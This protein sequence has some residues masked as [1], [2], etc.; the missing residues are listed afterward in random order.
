MQAASSGSDIGAQQSF[1]KCV[2][3]CPVYS[4]TTSMPAS[5]TSRI[6]R[7]RCSPFSSLVGALNF[8][9][10]SLSVMRLYKNLPS[11]PVPHPDCM[12]T[13]QLQKETP[14]NE[15]ALSSAQHRVYLNLPSAG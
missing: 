11:N 7:S 8:Q 1:R 3:S 4:S 6:H 13:F 15:S 10:L 9:D 2:A 14:E 12:F 5:A